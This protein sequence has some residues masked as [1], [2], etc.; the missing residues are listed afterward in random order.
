MVLSDA[1]FHHL[2]LLPLAQQAQRILHHP[3]SRTLN[4]DLIVVDNEYRDPNRDLVERLLRTEIYSRYAAALVLNPFIA[5]LLASVVE[6][7]RRPGSATRFSV[8]SYL[9]TFLQ[10][11]TF[12]CN[13]YESIQQ[14][15]REEFG[16]LVALERSPSLATLYRRTPEVLGALDPVKLTGAIAGN[17]LEHLAIG[18]RLFYVD[19]H[20]VVVRARNPVAIPL[21]RVLPSVCWFD[22]S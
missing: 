4:A 20:Y 17:Y 15:H 19:G 21:N 22:T 2:H 11:N 8:E 3:A 18:S 13:N 7:E 14:L 9:L 16:P 5:R 6:A 10:M 1:Q 12:G